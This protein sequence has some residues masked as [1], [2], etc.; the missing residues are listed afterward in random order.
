MAYA[1]VK[2]NNSNKIEIL[3]KSKSIRTILRKVTILGGEDIEFKSTYIIQK[4]LVLLFRNN[5]FTKLQRIVESMNRNN[6]THSPNQMWLF[7]NTNGLEEF[8]LININYPNLEEINESLILIGLP[9]YKIIK[10]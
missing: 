4:M 3:F 5:K 2:K 10:V 8:V 9:E 1:L 6:W 7:N